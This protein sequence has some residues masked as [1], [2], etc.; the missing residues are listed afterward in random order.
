MGTTLSCAG[1]NATLVCLEIYLYIGS[2]TLCWAGLNFS[3][4]SINLED[5]LTFMEDMLRLAKVCI[6]LRT[7]YYFEKGGSSV[8]YICT[9]IFHRFCV[10]YFYYCHWS[11][12]KSYPSRYFLLK[13]KK[14]WSLRSLQ[15]VSSSILSSCTITSPGKLRQGSILLIS[16]EHNAKKFN[17]TMW[18]NFLQFNSWFSPL[19]LMP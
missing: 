15:N 16:S 9:V 13:K 2:T 14:L 17:D 11:V 5:Y 8:C 6:N 3:W 19:I 4:Y 10:F 1:L 18:R 7:I 12:P